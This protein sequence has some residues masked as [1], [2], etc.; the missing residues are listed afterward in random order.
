M[1]F[2]KTVIKQSNTVYWVFAFFFWMFSLTKAFNGF[3]VPCIRAK[4]RTHRVFDTLDN[5]HQYSLQHYEAPQ[6][7]CITVFREEDVGQAG[8]KYMFKWIVTP[9]QEVINTHRENPETIRKAE[10]KEKKEKGSVDFLGKDNWNVEFWRNV[11]EN[12]HYV[13]KLLSKHHFYIK[14]LRLFPNF[15]T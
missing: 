12:N 13:L 1:G 7:N 6:L 5:L 4:L 14:T 10:K 15:P 11:L 2:R 3:R 8:T 9:K